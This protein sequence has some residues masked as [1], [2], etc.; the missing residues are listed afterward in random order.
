MPLHI[1]VT[2]A[3]TAF[4]G[5]IKSAC[6]LGVLLE[7][8]IGDTMRISLTDDP[9]VEVRACWTLLGA[10][11]LR[12]R[13]PEL[14]S[15][16]TCGRTQYPMIEIANEVERRLKEEGFKKPVKIAIMG[17]IVNGPGEAREADIGIAGGKGEA[18]LF[19]HGKPIK[20]LTGDNILDQFMDE[21]YKL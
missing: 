13:S 6:G 5:I 20:K 12:R 15:C 9:V 11:D 18:V 4:Q 21:I 16:P 3:G 1:G 14:I 7:E 17:C 10:L 2:E 8:G 19:I